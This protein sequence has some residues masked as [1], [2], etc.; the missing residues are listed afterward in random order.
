MLVHPVA[1]GEGLPI[2]TQVDTPLR[3][4]LIESI[5]FPKGAVAQVYLPA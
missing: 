3:F 1:L 4:K 5:S 2:F